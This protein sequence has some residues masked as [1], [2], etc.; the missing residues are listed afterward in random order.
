MFRVLAQTLLEQS[1]LSPVPLEVQPVHWQVKKLAERGFWKERFCS[2]PLQLCMRVCM[3]IPCSL[4]PCWPKCPAPVSAARCSVC[5]A[6]GAVATLQIAGR[7]AASLSAA[8]CPFI[9]ETSHG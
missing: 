9:V 7:R 8:L 2:L 6:E 1:H 5:A 4:A 3:R